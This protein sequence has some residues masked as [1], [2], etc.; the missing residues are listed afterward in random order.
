MQSR[1]RIVWL[2][3]ALLLL[4]GL[5]L[6]A[7]ASDQKPQFSPIIPQEQR[8]GA[9]D[10][11]KAD[12]IWD[13]LSLRYFGERTLIEGEDQD[14]VR[15][16]APFR[17]ENDALVPVSI[18]TK[19]AEDGPAITKVY[20]IVDVNPIPVAGVFSLSDK[21]PLETISTRVRVNG[22]TY[23][24]AIAE[25]SDGKL[26]MDKQVVKSR[27]V[28]CAA[29]PITSPEDAERNL[30][31]MRFKLISDNDEQ[32]DDNL[33]QLMISHPNATGMQKDQISLLYIPEHY[34]KQ[35]DVSFNG[36]Q[37]LSAETTYSISENP[38]FRFNFSPEE[39]GELQAR[40]V[41]TK[42]NVYILA[43]EITPRTE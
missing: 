35:V 3:L 25:T 24:R 19:A 14:V 41:D 15:L 6:L 21:R 28:A 26:F 30:G 40:I 34:V 29:P 39:K 10:E 33:L 22:Y 37:L 13:M 38:S 16:D 2:V 23:V 9:F 1:I 7:Q 11:E 18:N 32:Q 12:A 5:P 27:G 31:K 36:E 20:L 17:T 8:L 43:Q 4:I 42:D